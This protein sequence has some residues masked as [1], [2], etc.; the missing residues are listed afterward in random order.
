M[1]LTM[2]IYRTTAQKYASNP[3]YHSTNFK[4]DYV[5]ETTQASKQEDI[6][7]IVKL[8]HENRELKE[9]V[10]HKDRLLIKHRHEATRYEES[11][12]MLQLD[13]GKWTVNSLFLII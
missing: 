4:H 12:A 5:S 11:I 13:L 3:V 9:A 6:E 1:I 7:K 2:T 10:E 8:K